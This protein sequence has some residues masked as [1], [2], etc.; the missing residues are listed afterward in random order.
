MTQRNTSHSKGTTMS[1][2]TAPSRR[3][4]ISD[5]ERAEQ[6]RLWALVAQL[7][8]G[9]RVSADPFGDLYRATCGT[10]F[11]FIRSRV[12]GYHLAEDLTS[13]TF[14]RAHK[15]VDRLQRQTGSP[16]AWLVTIAR[17][18]VADHH[19]AASTRLVM[20]VDETQPRTP[21]GRPEYTETGDAT[22]DRVFGVRDAI[23]LL[24][25]I[26]RLTPAQREAVRLRYLLGESV[27]GTADQMGKEV[28]AVKALTYRA[29][30][31]LARDPEVAAMAPAWSLLA[32]A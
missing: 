18:L 10:V 8:G 3:K 5:A 2:T 14:E 17:N 27:A 23:A 25:A 30:R 15:R 29:T 12:G 20:Y 11:R 24:G 21:E 1:S 26:T 31:S 22:V 4:T 9:P 32:A 7:Q 6:D 28:G 13:D 16:A 19:K